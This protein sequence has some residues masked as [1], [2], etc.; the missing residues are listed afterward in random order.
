MKRI[1]VCILTVSI[2]ISL[3]GCG[4]SKNGKI[5]ST[6]AN[7]TE[8]KDDQILFFAQDRADIEDDRYNVYYY[9]YKGELLSSSDSTY[10]GLYAEN[11]LAPAYDQSTGNAGYVDKDGVFTIKPQYSDAA[12]FSKD[13]IALVKKTTETDDLDISK[14]GYIDSKGN[15]VTPCIYDK[16]TSFYDCG[17]AIVGI[18]ENT[19]DEDTVTKY[20]IIDKKGKTLFES[21]NRIIAVYEN[22]FVC[23]NA[24]YNYSN[25]ILFEKEDVDFELN[26]VSYKIGKDAV[27]RYIYEKSNDDEYKFIKTERFDG[28]DFVVEKT[29]Y[30]ISSKRVATTQSGLGYGIIKDGKTV[31]PFEYDSIV[32]CGDYFV[33]I[34]YQSEN[35][36]LDQVF[37]IYDSDYNKT[38]ENIEYAFSNRNDPYG[39]N[40]QLPNGYFQITIEDNDYEYLT[41]IIDYTG[42]IIVEPVYGRGIH[43]YSYEG[44]GVFDEY[45]FW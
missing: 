45:Y 25:E 29:K 27:Y 18:D 31:I 15:E 38:A 16:A 39:Y 28:K 3:V 21:E 7:K 32:E 14:C 6:N 44:C 37:D 9:N 10:I 35:N 8:Y 2:I 43:L 42:K 23:E 4:G 33:A 40:C 19:N 34:K 36:Y 30:E 11:G 5:K 20:S 26:P 41:G 17:Y 22:Y 13:G 24:I 1:I 12:P